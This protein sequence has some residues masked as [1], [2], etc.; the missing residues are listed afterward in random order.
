VTAP[1]SVHEYERLAAERVD[2]AVWCYFEGGAG[3]EWTL[4]ENR[5]AY[6]R[7]RFRPRVL[8][9]VEEITT[10][11]SVLGTSVSMPFLVAPIAY[12]QLLDPEGELAMARAAAD[13]G[14]IMCLSTFSSFTHAQVAAAAPGLVQ[15]AQL[16]VLRDDGLTLWHLDEAVAAGC[17][18]VVLTVDTPVL[19]RRERDLRVDF[20]LPEELQLPYVREAIGEGNENPA[21]HTPFFSRSVTWRDIERFSSHTRLP[22]LVKGIATR[23]DAV[24]ACEHGAAGIVV[25]NHGGRQLDGAPAT[26][27]ALPEVAAA[28]EGRIPV[29]LDGGIRRGADVLKALALGATATMGGRAPI[30]GLAV[31]GEQGV[32]HVL[33]LIRQEIETGLALLGCTE[34][35]QVGRS[36]VAPAVAYDPRA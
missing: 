28:V 32:R 3:D 36:H 10:A 23:E 26:L 15:W 29:L 20:T 4:R 12:Q 33:E 16:Y 1:L 35:Q 31:A 14:T 18:A 21:S 2:P 17:T 11:A 8:V 24:L 30:F 22:V 25:S 9:D 6:E 19:G 34:P 27:E 7:W 13:A 5:A